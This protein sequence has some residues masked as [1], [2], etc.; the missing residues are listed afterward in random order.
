MLCRQEGEGKRGNLDYVQEE[1][2]TLPKAILLITITTLENAYYYHHPLH[3]RGNQG[4]ERRACFS[5]W[6]SQ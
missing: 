4:S 5:R 6:R 2:G 3:R 1:P